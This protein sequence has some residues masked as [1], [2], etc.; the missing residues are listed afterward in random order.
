MEEKEE[1]D[2]CKRSKIS[3]EDFEKQ[4]KDI[5][6]TIKQVKDQMNGRWNK[7]QETVNNLVLKTNNDENSNKNQ[8]PYFRPQA[9]GSLNL[10]FHCAKPNHRFT[11]CTNATEAEKNK[12]REALRTRKFDFKKLNDKANLVAQQKKIKFNTEALNL[13]TPV[14]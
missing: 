13:N 6:N 7:V 3:K 14:Q 2:E 9:R 11:E 4:K 12:I 8:K 1:D 5:D 10:C